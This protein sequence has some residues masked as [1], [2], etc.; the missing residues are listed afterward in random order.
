[1]NMNDLSIWIG[2]AA[3][4]VG[5]AFL[6]SWVLCLAVR[7]LAPRWGL[8]DRPGGHKGHLVPTPLGGGVA[9]WL[10]TISLLALGLAMFILGRGLLPESLARHAGGV[11]LQLPELIEILALASV[12][13]AMGLVDDFKN[14]DWRLRLG[15]QVVCATILA[16]SGIHVT[17]FWPFT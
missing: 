1:M 15:I 10:T 11:L 12:I 3:G 5:S 14:L 9:I 7:R 6:L 17:L 13:M 16:A 2:V 4:L 8:V